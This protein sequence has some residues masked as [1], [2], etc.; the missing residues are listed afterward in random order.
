MLRRLYTISLAVVALLLVVFIS[1]DKQNPDNP[2]TPTPSTVAV[3]GVSLDKSSADLSVGETLSLVATVSPSNASDKTVTWSSSNAEVASVT[4]GTVKA[5]KAGSAT[6]TVTTNSGSKTASCSIKVTEAIKVESVA[7]SNK[8]SQIA[9]GDSVQLTATITPADATNKNVTWRSTNTS[10]AT[11]KD[12]VV[13]AIKEG[14]SLIIVKTEDGGKADTCAV[15]VISDANFIHVTSVSF[16]YYN[17]TVGVGSTM[18]FT[19]QIMPENATNKNATWKSSNTNVATIDNNGLLTAIAIGETDIS[20]TAEDGGISAWTTITVVKRV[21]VTSITLEDSSRYLKVGEGT[22]LYA[23]IQPEE[24]TNKNIKW[25][26]SNPSVATVDDNGNITA[27]A[28]GE[29]EITATCEDNGMTATCKIYV[30]IPV[31]YIEWIDLRTDF[32]VGDVHTIK[33]NVYPENATYKE[34]VWTSSN[35]DVATIENGTVT[36]LAPGKTDM[37]ITSRDRFQWYCWEINVHPKVPVTGITISESSRSMCIGDIAY[38]YA[39]V[40]PDNATNRNVKWSSSNTDVAT[41]NEH[42]EVRAIGEGE[43]EITVTAEDGGLKASCKI[44]VRVP[45]QWI[46][47]SNNPGEYFTGM[48]YNIS[49]KVHPENATNQ[50]LVWDS[51]DKNVATV[52]NNGT[53]TAIKKGYTQITI[54]VANE[55]HMTGFDVLVKERV[56]VTGVSINDPYREMHIGETMGLWANVQPEDASVREVTWSSSSPAVATIDEW[57]NVTAIALGETEI[58][59]TTM[60]GGFKATCTIKVGEYTPEWVELNTYDLEIKAGETAQLTATVYPENAVNK[61]VKWSSSDSNV[62]TVDSKGTITA[63][64][65]GWCNIVATTEVGQRRAECRV[66]VPQVPVTGISFDSDTASVYVGSTLKLNPKISPNNATNKH[67]YWDTN[68]WSIAEV[69]DGSVKGKS[70]GVVTITARTEEG[71]FEAS[72]KVTVKP[73]VVT[74]I[75]LSKTSVEL[76]QGDEITLTATITPTNATNKNV[77]WSSSSDAAKVENGVVK[78]V[79]AGEVTI[80]AKTEDGGYTA[81]CKLYIKA[82]NGVDVGEWGEGGNNEGTAN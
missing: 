45:V 30:V 75:S 39:E 52:D 16:S 66:Y 50:T 20:L 10:I 11:V 18:A 57:G 51:S 54:S 21:P 48:T 47:I 1:C 74:G 58:T 56:P 65:H 17:S 23:N 76:T 44:S 19:P 8:S 79:R 43:A 61:N 28:L 14:N 31:Q 7:L 68:N 59:A 78:A 38:L 27:V 77:I 49:A 29:T 26:S 15:S 35:K 22:Y 72:C 64:A 33:A 37:T 24:A 2:P 34:L 70:P 63:V 69:E 6:I 53:L 42:G 62:A 67:V 80:T 81:Q 55:D 41:V 9:V 71:G 32:T 25:S 4:A 12:G 73:V 60:D 40:Q 36:A 46:E 82:Q 3:T 5:L 13:K